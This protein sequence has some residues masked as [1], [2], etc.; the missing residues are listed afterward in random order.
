MVSN[1]LI[2]A[3]SDPAAMIQ[4]HFIEPTIRF[5]LPALSDLGRV[6]D[7]ETESLRRLPLPSLPQPLD[8]YLG[9]W[10]KA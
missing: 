8:A 5:V 2:E 1:G 4:R 6:A 3:V 10:E 7:P 9:P